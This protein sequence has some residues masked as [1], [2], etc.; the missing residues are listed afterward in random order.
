MA[1][2]GQH[3]TILIVTGMSGVGKSSLVKAGLLPILV[4]PGLVEH[5]IAWR[6]AVFKPNVTNQTLLSGFAAALIEKT[7]LPELAGA[8]G[9]L[10]ALLQ[11]PAALTVALTRSLDLATR[12]NSIAR[13]RQWAIQ[14]SS[15]HQNARILFSTLRRKRSRVAASAESMP[16]HQVGNTKTSPS[17][18]R[19]RATSIGATVWFWFTS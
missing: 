19:S 3:F 11:D 13:F 18:R 17:Q 15:F 1:H 10:E 4:R 6:R 12:P 7:A 16:Y 9:G 2:S 14:P 8:T 5:V